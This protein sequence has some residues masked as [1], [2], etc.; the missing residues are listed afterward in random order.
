MIGPV[1]FAAHTTGSERLAAIG[2]SVLEGSRTV[3]GTVNEYIRPPLAALLDKPPLICAICRRTWWLA[4][5][6]ALLPALSGCQAPEPAVARQWQTQNVLY[7]NPML[8]AVRDPY[9]LWENVVDVV[10]DYFTIEREEPVRVVD[11]VVT[12]GRLDTFPEIASTVFEPWRPDSIGRYAK[13]EATL[14]PI[15]RYAEVRVRPSS[16]GFLVEVAVY[17]ER[18]ELAR[19]EHA[20]FNPATFRND[21]SLTRVVSGSDRRPVRSYWI[22]LGR[23]PALEQKILSEI[24]A[25]CGMAQPCPPPR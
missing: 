21:G 22:S 23:E 17:K 5:L 14:Q 24:A 12:E 2:G 20:S 8:V 9:I 6:A 19:P 10:D 1:V 4:V 15:R 16:G 3:V 25:R 11:Q 13:W 7:P 18:E